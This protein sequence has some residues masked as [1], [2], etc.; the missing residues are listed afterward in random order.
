MERTVTLG[1]AAAIVVVCLAI[2]VDRYF[3]PDHIAEL[4]PLR[5]LVTSEQRLIVGSSSDLAKIFDEKGYTLSAVHTGKVPVP[6][7]LLR[8]W[9]EGFDEM[10]RTKRKKD[11]FIRALLPMILHVNKAVTAQRAS[12]ME[13]LRLREAGEVLSHRERAWL[14]QLAK[15]YRTKPQKK[16]VL[17]RRVA[18]IPPSLAIAQAAIETGW[19]TSRFAIAGNAMFG[20]WTYDIKKG[21]RPLK[22][23]AGTRHAVKSYD[24]LVES[25]WDYARNLNTNPAYRELRSARTAGAKD[26]RALAG[27]LGRY[28]ERGP[29]YVVLI[30]N[31]IKQN[32]LARLDKAGFAH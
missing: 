7:L 26:G 21:L 22:A 18:P 4:P 31:I 19:G 10:K 17:L 16:S 11:L 27:K 8:E 23:D 13:L 24:R 14:K 9:P 25:A 28:S 5:P 15:L 1:V 29:A 30:R 2:L 3:P 32:N 6:H 12:M 20:Q